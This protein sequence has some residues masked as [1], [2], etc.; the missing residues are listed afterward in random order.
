VIHI[1]HTVGRRL[2]VAA[3]LSANT[4]SSP[5]SDILKLT[6]TYTHIPE[7]LFDTSRWQLIATIPSLPV[8]PLL[9]P[10]LLL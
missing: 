5:K 1:Y 10:E 6:I 3:D 4:Y 9:N 8:D 2:Y 7:G